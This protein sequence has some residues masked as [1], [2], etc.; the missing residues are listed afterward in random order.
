[1]TQNPALQNA[2]DGQPEP[3]ERR[4]NPKLIE[5]VEVTLEAYLGEARLTVGALSTIEKD[6]V[7]ALD[8]SFDRA[9]ELRLNGVAVA[10]G[11]LVSVGDR[12][13][14][15]LVEIVK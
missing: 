4:I 14:I 6:A 2:S 1:M 10:S 3:G 8:A 13:G 7:I 9:V 11:E 12:F 15:R 5:N